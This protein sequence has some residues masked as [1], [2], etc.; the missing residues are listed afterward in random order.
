MNAGTDRSALTP[1]FRDGTL[2]W[3]TAP[4]FGGKFGRALVV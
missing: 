4:L 1:V 2:T 3:V